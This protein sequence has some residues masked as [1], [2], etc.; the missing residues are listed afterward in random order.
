MKTLRSILPSNVVSTTGVL[1]IEIT[2]IAFDSRKVIR[3]N[4]FVALPG[5]HIDGSAFIFDAL[6]RGAA[7]V[8]TEGCRKNIEV[9]VVK[10]DDARQALSEISAKFYEDPS[11]KIKLIGV[12]GTKGKTTI[13]YLTQSIL[14]KAFGHA[15]RI[16]TV[17]YDMEYA[18]IPATN[19]TPESQVLQYLMDQALKNGIK[20]GVVEVSSHS[21]KTWR[22]EHLSFAVAGF[23][24]LSLEHS[25]FH[26]DMADYFNT[27][28]R[29]FKEIND[30]QKACVIGIDDDY[31]KKLADECRNAGLKIQTVSVHNHDADFYCEKLHMTGTSS[32]FSLCHNGEQYQCHINLAGEYNTFNAI[33]AAAMSKA[34]GA[35]WPEITAGLAALKNVPGRLEAIPNDRGINVIVDYAHSPAALENVLKAVRPITRNRLIAVFGCGGNRSQEKRPVMGKIAFNN[36]DVVI[37]TSDNPRKE[38]PETI[39]EQIMAGIKDELTDCPKDVYQ[40]I[41]RKTAIVKALNMANAGDTVVIAGKGHETGQYFADRTIP[42]DDREIARHFFRKP[43]ND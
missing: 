28:K 23:T 2:G 38:A 35:D 20:H 40:E 9:P 8:L 11:Q 17:E 36:A 43:E 29:L 21:L 37:V 10:V 18:R 7:A 41:D 3:G 24:N 34:A 5:Q 26:P 1:D 19:T 6:E 14:K 33:M 22:V 39:I 15:F 16:G 13:T 4:L 42:F 30:L 32:D 12:T 31:G 27:K 25:E